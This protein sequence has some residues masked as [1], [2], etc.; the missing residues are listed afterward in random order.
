MANKLG[1]GLCAV[2]VCAL[3]GCGPR[4]GGSGRI[5]TRQGY[6]DLDVLVRSHPGWSGVAQY[7]L[8]LTRLRHASVRLDRPAEDAQLALLPA[9]DPQAPPS[10]A[11]LMWGEKQQLDKIRQA[12]VAQVR[13][14]RALARQRQLA[15]LKEA[16][17]READADYTRYVRRA[18]RDYLRGVRQTLARG[19][20]Q[21]LN[22]SLQIKALQDIVTGWKASAPPT[23]RLA[24][25][26]R[27][28]T[29]KLAQAAQLDGERA[30]TFRAAEAKRNG[31][32]AAAAVF[33]DGYVRHLAGQKEAVLQMQDERQTEAFARALVK[34]EQA[35][36]AS[37]SV[38]VVVPVAPAGS[39]DAEVLPA[40]RPA[41][42]LS[43]G[44]AAKSLRQLQMAQTRL[45]AQRA[46]WV[47]FLYDDTR[48]AALD[49]AKKRH[50]TV[51]FGKTGSGMAL[52]A[53]LAQILSSQGWK[54]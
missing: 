35:L 42:A 5:A 15:P 38:Q 12:Q 28:L 31:E 16:W 23:P 50:W 19:D 36:L 40:N 32:I 43:S 27:D 41:P 47:A 2:L 1:W 6:A 44:S 8:A 54:T 48:A 11:A 20:V 17:Q 33:R 7:D 30:A 45:L 51:A 14:R 37:Q 46:R 49:A 25:A 9:D 22:L 4:H 52:T 13:E 21:R 53:P 24:Q 10:P 26:R 18:Q 29:T 3:A 39:L 34:Q